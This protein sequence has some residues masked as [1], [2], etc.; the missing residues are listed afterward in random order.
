VRIRIVRGV[1]VEVVRAEKDFE[2]TTGPTRWKSSYAAAGMQ[3]PPRLRV[4]ESRFSRD[5]K[6]MSQGE[7]EIA[8]HT[9][10]HKPDP[11]C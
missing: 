3:I 8:A 2:R 4:A 7:D 11:R 6:R 1:A 10:G 5:A 9:P